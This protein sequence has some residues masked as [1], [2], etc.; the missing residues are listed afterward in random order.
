ML[1]QLDRLEEQDGLALH[2]GRSCSTCDPRHLAGKRPIRNLGDAHHGGHSRPQP[3]RRILRHIY[4]D[5]DHGALH[6]G[7][8]EGAARRIGL[9][10]AAD[11][12]VALGDDAL[13]RGDD[14]LIGLL[15]V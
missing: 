1:V 15:L 8:H 11:V 6:D 2:Q 13:E 5:A 12:D 9:H 10:Q 7:E 14:A 4:L 3:E